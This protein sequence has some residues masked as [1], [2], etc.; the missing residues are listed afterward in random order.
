V[1]QSLTQFAPFLS[2]RKTRLMIVDMNTD[3]SCTPRT[4]GLEAMQK[5]S[6]AITALQID[7]LVPEPYVT[8]H[9]STIMH[10]PTTFMLSLPVVRLSMAS[11]DRKRENLGS[12]WLPVS[13]CG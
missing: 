5:V 11:A 12:G 13:R 6:S 1:V 10:V 2:I 4:G 3:V 8:T 7:V 9:W